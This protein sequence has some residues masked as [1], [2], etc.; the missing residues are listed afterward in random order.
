[1]FLVVELFIL[2]LELLGDVID[3]REI[4][5]LQSLLFLAHTLNKLLLSLL[6]PLQFLLV[7]LVDFF[8]QL[9]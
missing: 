8:G 5:S 7:D 6:H 9:S 2:N 1:L 4:M 3:L